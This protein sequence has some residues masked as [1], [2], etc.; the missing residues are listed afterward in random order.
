M[1]QTMKTLLERLTVPAALL[2]LAALVAV[3]GRLA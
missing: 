1:E 3:L 2:A